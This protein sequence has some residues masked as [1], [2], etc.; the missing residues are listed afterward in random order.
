MQKTAVFPPKTSEAG[1]REKTLEQ[2]ELL[3][4]RQN[5]S[6]ESR[7]SCKDFSDWIK[8]I[9]FLKPDLK[10]KFLAAI[11]PEAEIQP[12]SVRQ[13]PGDLK[14]LPSESSRFQ[15]LTAGGW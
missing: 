12:A 2:D 13:P 14:K 6:L 1:S 11:L 5:Q 15:K 4:G 8:Q 7:F 10:I 9:E 3:S